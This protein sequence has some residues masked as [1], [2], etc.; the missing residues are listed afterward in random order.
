MDGNRKD[1]SAVAKNEKIAS[2][3]LVRLQTEM[4]EW[5]KTSED[6]LRLKEQKIVEMGRRV[7]EGEKELKRVRA[8]NIMLRRNQKEWLGSTSK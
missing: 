6:N 7:E 3:N 8:E 5:K 4:R 2:R 1:K